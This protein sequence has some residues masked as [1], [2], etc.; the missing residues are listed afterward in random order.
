MAFFNFRRNAATPESASPDVSPA[1]GRAA[2]GSASPATEEL[3][4]RA[5]ADSSHSHQYMRII[6]TEQPQGFQHEPA[7]V[8]RQRRILPSR[9]PHRKRRG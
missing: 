1:K 2:K 5:R 4:R 6:L 9:Q 3:S 7:S 8:C